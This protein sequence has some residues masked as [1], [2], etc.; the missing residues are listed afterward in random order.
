MFSRGAVSQVV[1]GSRVQDQSLTEVADLPAVGSTQHRLQALLRREPRGP[2]VCSLFCSV[3]TLSLSKATSSSGERGSV[4]DRAS[5]LPMLPA[6]RALGT[7]LLW[8]VGRRSTC[9][10]SAGRLKTCPHAQPAALH[11]HL[12]C[13][14]LLGLDGALHAVPHMPLPG[15]TDL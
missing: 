14:L 12:L 2:G 3:L 6:G 1:C 9:K 5:Q 7:G 11:A 13:G 10:C 15:R 4:R 8:R